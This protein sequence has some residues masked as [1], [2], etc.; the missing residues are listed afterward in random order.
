MS[1]P[2]RPDTNVES[3][4]NL[5]SLFRDCVRPIL[6]HLQKKD[7]SYRIIDR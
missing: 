5:L 4:R 2:P 7:A 6:S 3:Q 1:P